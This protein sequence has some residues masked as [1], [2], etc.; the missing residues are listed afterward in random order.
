MHSKKVIESL[1][2]EGWCLRGIKGSHHIFVH[3]TKVGHLVVPHPKKD[4]GFGLT[5]S[6]FKQAG[7]CKE[8]K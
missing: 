2:K 3:P 1:I 8:V 7:I 6:I 5:R 4:L